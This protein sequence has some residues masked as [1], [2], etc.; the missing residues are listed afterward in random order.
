MLDF[1]SPRILTHINSTRLVQYFC[2]NIFLKFQTV[3]K[4][5]QLL[6]NNQLSN[7]RITF[8]QQI[9]SNVL[10]YSLCNAE[11]CNELADPSP[12]HCA[13]TTQLLSKNYRRGWRAVG[14]SVFDLT[15]PRFELQTSRSIDKRALPFDQLVGI[16]N[17]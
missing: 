7:I 11:A 6:P 1:C 2:L 5:F 13:R 15:N 8:Q 12:R 9:K 10:L 14:N 16:N 4:A 17:K 3:M